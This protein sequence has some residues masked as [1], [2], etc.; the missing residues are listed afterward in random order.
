MGHADRPE[1]VHTEHRKEIGGDG[2]G[3]C[4]DTARDTGVVDE[5]I[6]TGAGLRHRPVGGGDGV[7]ARDI[8]FDD[9]DVGVGA[10]GSD[11]P[12]NVVAGF[13]SAHAHPDGV[14]GSGKTTAGFGAEASGAPVTRTV[15]AM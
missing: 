4:S 12:R 10:V 2:V 5:D 11:L 1:Q 6:E 7:V 9:A 3:G 8:E 13:E 14:S 15:D